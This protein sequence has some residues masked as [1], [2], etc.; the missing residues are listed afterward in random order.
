M[1][2]LG[3]RHRKIIDGR[4]KADEGEPVLAVRGAVDVVAIARQVV[5]QQFVRS[6][7]RPADPVAID[8][9]EPGARPQHRLPVVR[10]VD[11]SDGH[12]NQTPNSHRPSFVGNGSVALLYLIAEPTSASLSTRLAKQR[13]APGPT[14]ESAARHQLNGLLGGPFHEALRGCLQH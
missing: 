7:L 2:K 6:R 9:A 3:L 8:L 10:P 1:R 13:Q 5:D 4:A 11:G 12:L 14:D